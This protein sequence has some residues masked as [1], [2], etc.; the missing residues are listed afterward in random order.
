MPDPKKKPFMQLSPRQRVLDE[1][2]TEQRDSRL[3]R[4]AKRRGQEMAD[5]GEGTASDLAAR[6]RKS[7]SGRTRGVNGHE[8]GMMNESETPVFEKRMSDAMAS[9]LEKRR[10]QDGKPTG[11]DAAMRGVVTP[12]PK[13]TPSMFQK[14]K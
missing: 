8:Y 6:E 5:W 1:E 7:I 11:Y 2:T 3:A 14:K 10:K 4:V 9:D 12:R 13:M